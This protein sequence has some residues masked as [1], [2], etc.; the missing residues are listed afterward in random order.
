MWH[1]VNRMG[2]KLRQRALGIKRKCYCSIGWGGG[3]SFWPS[4]FSLSLQASFCKAAS[5]SSQA[6]PEQRRAM[7]GVRPAGSAPLL[8]LTW[9]SGWAMGGRCSQVHV[10]LQPLHWPLADSS[11]VSV[12]QFPTSCWCRC[13]GRHPFLSPSTGGKQ[14]HIFLH[15]CLFA[16]TAEMMAYRCC[17]LF[18]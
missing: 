17:I 14:K 12:L 8:G 5:S 18:A 7:W 16:M 13:S 4:P 15:C 1:A 10:V 3:W 6:W 2:V 9:D 11:A